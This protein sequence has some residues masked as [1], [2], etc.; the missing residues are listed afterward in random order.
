MS[1]KKSPTIDSIEPNIWPLACALARLRA[2]DRSMAPDERARFI[3]HAFTEHARA[4]PAGDPPLKEGRLLLEFAALHPERLPLIHSSGRVELWHLGPNSLVLP[5]QQNGSQTFAIY[6]SPP[7]DIR[8]CLLGVW[9]RARDIEE[10]WPD[11]SASG[12]AEVEVV[13]VSS[14]AKIKRRP[15]RK[16]GSGE[17]FDQ[18]HIDRMGELIREKKAVSAN[19]AATLVAHDASGAC[20]KAIVA[21]LARKFRKQYD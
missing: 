12:A 17:F 18:P 13:K 4:F 3:R 11:S 20:E 16:K 14:T 6:P 7:T 9:C 5:H 8:L 21:R 19:H 15:G 10:A 1:V 2:I